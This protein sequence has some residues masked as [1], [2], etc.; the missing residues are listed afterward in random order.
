MIGLPL[1]VLCNH[2]GN[3]RLVPLARLGVHDRDR[4]PVIWLRLRCRC[5]C[6]DV[7]R[8]VLETPD[9]L[10]SFLGGAL[11]EPRKRLHGK[12]GQADT[13]FPG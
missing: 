2:C 12:R 13:I 7:E 5:G 11:P 8:I 3:R 10:P 9:D 1:A 6:Y 4:R